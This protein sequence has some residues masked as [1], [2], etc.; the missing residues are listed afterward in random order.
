MPDPR[1]LTAAEAIREA[2][3]ICL[4]RDPRVFVIGEGVA[5]PKAIF[6]TTAGLLERF[7][8]ERVMEMPVAEN[9]LTGVVI[10][11]ALTGLRPIL[12]HQRVD[13]ALLAV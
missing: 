3:E 2:T 12:I 10:G 13:F 9:G 8:A 7:G 1:I 4:E 11:A 6:G 5:D